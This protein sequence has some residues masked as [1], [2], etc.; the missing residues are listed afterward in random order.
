MQAGFITPDDRLVGYRHDQPHYARIRPDGN[1]E[2]A[3]GSIAAAPTKAMKDAVGVASNGWDFWQ[4]ER[5]RERL[6]TVR[7]RLSPNARVSGSP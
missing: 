5:T 2:T 6:D 3:A 4:I 7:R 1:I